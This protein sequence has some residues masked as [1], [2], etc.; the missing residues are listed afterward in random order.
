MSC[1]IEEELLAL[2]LSG[3]L[4]AEQSASVLAH[5][6]ECESCRNGIAELRLSQQLLASTFAE[7]EEEDLRSVRIALKGKLTPQFGRR[8]WIS[9]AA[10]A[11]GLALFLTPVSVRR[12]TDEQVHRVSTAQQS[13]VFVEPRPTPTI[14]ALRPLGQVHRRI[15]RA[16]TQAGLKNVVLSTNVSG[17]S[18]L[19]M[20]TADPDVLILMQMDDHTHAN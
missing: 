12:N 2:S 1:P 9:M 18:E 3:D 4:D 11:A 15:H 8:V 19:R 17:K 16:I 7:P 5:V 13:D 6:K 20:M 14:P 10:V